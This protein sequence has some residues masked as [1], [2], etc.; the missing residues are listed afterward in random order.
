MASRG[1]LIANAVAAVTVT[2][3][4]TAA[5]KTAVSNALVARAAELGDAV[6]AARG[7]DVA[8]TEIA[9]LTISLGA[10]SQLPY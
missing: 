9:R 3:T 5:D 1:S 7:Y 8:F 6:V 4:I 10:A 2:S